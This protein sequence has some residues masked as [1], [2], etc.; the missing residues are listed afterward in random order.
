MW[1]QA[2]NW[3]FLVSCSDR[4]ADFGLD[5]GEAIGT[6]G[7]GGEGGFDYRRLA[8]VLMNTTLR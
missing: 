8:Q 4:T 5:E 1:A 6:A 7:T 3:M 2:A